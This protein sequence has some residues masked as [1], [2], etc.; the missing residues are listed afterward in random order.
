[1]GRYR[2]T[3]G[4]SEFNGNS[5]DK[6]ISLSS[7]NITLLD[8]LL[9]RARNNAITQSDADKLK[10]LASAIGYKKDRLKLDHR[11]KLE[12][13]QKAVKSA[14]TRKAEQKAATPKQEPVL[15]AN[16]LPPL[17]PNFHNLPLWRQEMVLEERERMRKAR[18][19]PQQRAH[20]AVSDAIRNLKNIHYEMRRMRDGYSVSTSYRRIPGSV[21]KAFEVL[22][23]RLPA[24]ADA[25]VKAA[26]DYDSEYGAYDGKSFTDVTKD[27]RNEQ[28]LL[29]AAMKEELAPQLS[30]AQIA[31]LGLPATSSQREAV[32]FKSTAKAEFTVPPR[33]MR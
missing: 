29:F 5:R 6:R 23:T 27:I 22:S 16:G 14:M 25:A 2:V 28:R 31:S 13:T 12:R 26:R 3:P 18:L 32:D 33:P 19:T 7:G 10:K 4:S 15:D 1:M 9:Y 30:S 8:T 21:D 17:S 24:A 11:D 20:E